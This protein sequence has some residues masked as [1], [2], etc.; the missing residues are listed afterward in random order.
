[1][2]LSY[3]LGYQEII[4]VHHTRRQIFAGKPDSTFPNIWEWLIYTSCMSMVILDHFANKSNTFQHSL[5][6]ALPFPPWVSTS[7]YPGYQENAIKGTLPPTQPKRVKFRILFKVDRWGSL[8]QISFVC[9]LG[10]GWILELEEWSKRGSLRS[11]CHLQAL[12]KVCC[13][14][15][16][17]TNHGVN[18]IAWTVHLFVHHYNRAQWKRHNGKGIAGHFGCCRLR[19]RQTTIVKWW[20]ALSKMES[21]D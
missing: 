20:R 7:S 15:D 1:M 6:L 11:A 12:S 4:S 8:I 2:A 19:W 21:S 13:W 9:C 18:H 10:V 16:Q 14:L 5:S 17:Q 3:N